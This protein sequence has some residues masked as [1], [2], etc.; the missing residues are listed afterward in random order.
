MKR[1]RLCVSICSLLFL[2]KT[3][4][5][6]EPGTCPIKKTSIVPLWLT[7]GLWK[8]FFFFLKA[9]SYILR[10]AYLNQSWKWLLQTSGWVTMRSLWAHTERATMFGGAWL[11]STTIQGHLLMHVLIGERLHVRV[12]RARGWVC[13]LSALLCLIDLPAQKHNSLKGCIKG[14][15]AHFC[16]FVIN[17]VGHSSP[18]WQSTSVNIN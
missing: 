7:V 9:T 13:L 4:I 17:V 5:D 6:G 3:V 8:L 1:F 11:P 10:R 2:C 18:S 16:V 12:L 15:R 14:V